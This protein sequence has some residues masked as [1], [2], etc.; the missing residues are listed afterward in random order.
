MRA[1]G[2]RR[3]ASKGSRGPLA[4]MHRGR[5]RANRAPSHGRRG[6]GRGAPACG[7]ARGAATRVQDTREQKAAYEKRAARGA[8]EELRGRERGQRNCRGSGTGLSA[9][10]ARNVGAAA[11]NG[12]L[13]GKPAVFRAGPGV[14]GG[15]CI[16]GALRG[17]GGAW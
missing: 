13:W 4:A 8:G 15:Y 12:P 7:C 10:V 6:G 16:E 9:G 5:C 17:L 14:N 11:S 3:T 2:P 1:L